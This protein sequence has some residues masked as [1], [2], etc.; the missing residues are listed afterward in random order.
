MRQRIQIVLILGMAAAAIRLGW[1]LYERH[2]D[3]VKTT[4]QQA[5]RL[6]PDYYVTPKKLYP[7]DLKSARQ[8]TQ[9]PVWVK[10]GYAYPYYSYD[11][12]S[13]RANIT[14]EV[15]K[16]LPLQ[17]L[18]IKDV[19]LAPVPG[20]SNKKQVLAVFQQDGN[21]YAAPVGT[22]QD[23]D[24]KFFSD[25]MLFIQDPHELYKHWPAAIWQQIDQHQAKP[26]MDELQIGFSLGIGFLEAGS[27]D[28]DRNLDYPDG[29]NPLRVSFHDGKAIQIEPG[30]KG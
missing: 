22:R 14:K 10:V 11:S 3:T 13:R 29:G 24:Y 30:P 21:W 1:I 7:Y 20:D 27:D 16:L 5:V 9:Q 19:V 25:D 28:T 23:D 4:S 2:E 6:N 12:A 17:K 26:G 15:G 8:L 18:E